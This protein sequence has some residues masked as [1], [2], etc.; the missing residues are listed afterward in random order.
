RWAE[1]PFEYRPERDRKE[2]WGVQ[3]SYVCLGIR[4][5]IRV[6]KELI[7]RGGRRAF[8]ARAGAGVDEV[9][10]VY[11]ACKGNALHNDPEGNRQ[12]VAE[13]MVGMLLSLLNNLRNAHS[14]VAAGLWKREQNRGLQLSGRTV[15]LIGYGNNGQ[16]MARCLSGFGVNILAYDKY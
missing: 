15:A 14:E 4:P 13:H 5:K 12:A 10:G 2:G 7:E 8:I 9:E 16:A 3:G 6:G 11:A 1:I